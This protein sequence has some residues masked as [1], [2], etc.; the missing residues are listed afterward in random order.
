VTAVAVP[1]NVGSGSNV[2]VPFTFTVY[3]PSLATVN[4]VALHVGT[5]WFV[6]HNFTVVAIKGKDDPT[7]S[8]AVGV[9]VWFVSQLPDDVSLTAIGN[10]GSPTVG[11]IVALSVCPN[12]S[13]A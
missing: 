6:S 13:E 9:M 12:E 2:T 3:V 7:V 4:V 5:D 10:G 11:V 1:L 8:L